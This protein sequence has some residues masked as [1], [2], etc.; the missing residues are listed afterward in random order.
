LRRGQRIKQCNRRA[1]ARGAEEGHAADA[2][3]TGQATLCG[4]AAAA[5]HAAEPWDAAISVERL[6]NAGVVPL[7]SRSKRGKICG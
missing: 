7:L 2:V 6:P 1:E 3:D 5:E 4:D